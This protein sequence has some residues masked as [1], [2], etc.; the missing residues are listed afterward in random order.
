VTQ[1]PRIWRIFAPSNLAA[2][3][4]VDE[5]CDGFGPYEFCLDNQTVFAIPVAPSYVSERNAIV[6]AKDWAGPDIKTCAN[7]APNFRASDNLKLGFY[8]SSGSANAPA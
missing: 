4:M 7:A 3:I 2:M 8:A 1:K 5:S 6:E